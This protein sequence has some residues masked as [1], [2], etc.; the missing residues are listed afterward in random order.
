MAKQPKMDGAQN[1]QGQDTELQEEGGAGR[2]GGGA[3]EGKKKGPAASLGSPRVNPFPT[4]GP[5]KSLLMGQAQED[6]K[7]GPLC[8]KPPPTGS[9]TASC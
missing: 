2:V 8:G 3:E 6:L 7:C 1:R 4:M 5:S 9:P